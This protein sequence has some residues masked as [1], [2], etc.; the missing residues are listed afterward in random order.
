MNL[1]PPEILR[2]ILLESVNQDSLM[3]ETCTGRELG[4]GTANRLWK[5]CKRWKDIAESLPV[6]HRFTLL[7]QN[8]CAVTGG[9][10]SSALDD[11]L[12]L[13]RK[14]GRRLEVRVEVM[15]QELCN[16]EGQL[17]CEALLQLAKWEWE[18]FSYTSRS[19]TSFDMVVRVLEELSRSGGTWVR[20]ELDLRHPYSFNDLHC[21]IGILDEIGGMPLL[22]KMALK[23]DET[24]DGG[25]WT[26][27]IPTA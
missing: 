25:S 8:H 14:S 24:Y 22:E 4:V 15:E 13:A 27:F 10:T 21:M 20:F 5:V 3:F 12:H 26:R 7:H 6:W 17:L 11:C 1:Q 18:V 9:S 23:I 19:C 2:E 16:E